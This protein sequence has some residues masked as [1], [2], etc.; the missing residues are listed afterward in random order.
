MEIIK[1]ILGILGMIAILPSIFLVPAII[2]TGIMGVA[3]KDYS[4]F[5]K[6][7]KIWGYTL[8]ALV[9]VLFLHLI[10]TFIFAGTK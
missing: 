1:F 5:K 8:L 2:I 3:K 10:A 9:I 7:L 6:F 4:N